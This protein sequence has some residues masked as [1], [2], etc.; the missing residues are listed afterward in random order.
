M[1][2][3]RLAV[4]AAPDSFGGALD[5]PRAAQ[6]ISDGWLRVR[7]GDEVVLRPMADGG[8]GTLAALRVALG[9]AAQARQAQT[10]DGRGRPKAS[11]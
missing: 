8:E 3:I 4:V 1:D 7:P 6:A 5:A 11:A 10:N 2:S 9:D